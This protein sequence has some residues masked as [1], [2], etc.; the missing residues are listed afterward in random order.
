VILP[1]PLPLQTSPDPLHHVAAPPP[2]HLH[3]V[4][5]LIKNLPEEHVGE[6]TYEE[7][8]GFVLPCVAK[9]YA[10]P[11]IFSAKNCKLG[12]VLHGFQE[13]LTTSAEVAAAKTEIQPHRKLVLFVKGK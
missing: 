3:N 6:K 8:N 1:Y 9:S 10:R 4:A 12:Y 2:Q 7:V 5:L 13:Q 11:K